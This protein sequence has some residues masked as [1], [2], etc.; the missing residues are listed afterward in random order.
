MGKLKITALALALPSAM[1]AANPAIAVAPSHQTAS[2]IHD[3]GV[4][5]W[6][7]RRGPRGHQHCRRSN[8][9]TGM[10]IGGAG[11]ALIGRE[12][13]GGRN[14]TLGT[15]AG[16]AGGALIGREIQRSRSRCR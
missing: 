7:H 11:G 16:A 2:A 9:T 1:V 15:I 10:I 8:G 4:T 14:R 3:L 6:E 5:G 12:I 13:D